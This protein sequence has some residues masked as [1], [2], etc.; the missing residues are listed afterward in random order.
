MTSRL[1]MGCLLIECL[2]TGCLCLL[3]TGTS[4]AAPVP[5]LG[6]PAPAFSLSD[7]QHRAHPLSGFR[8]APVALFFFCGC[9]PCRRC[10]SLWAQA[11]QAETSA[12]QTETSAKQA[13]ASP[14]HHSL[15]PATLIV[16]SGDAASASDFM[17]ETGLDP[18]TTTLLFDPR[19]Q[20]SDTYG[21]TVCPRVFLLDAAG[22]VRY[23]N[24]EHGMDP[25][26]MPTAAIISRTLAALQSLPS[27]LEKTSVSAKMSHSN[28]EGRD[29]NRNT[30]KRHAP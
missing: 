24:N 22:R 8:R 19:E 16:Y 28:N 2:L 4:L 20:V 5:I 17:A 27:S 25:Q 3:L 9:D 30:R 21:V 26:T 7:S 10:A 18:K 15:A 14:S 6:R 12:K 29:I 1:C 23:T 13:E 11:Q